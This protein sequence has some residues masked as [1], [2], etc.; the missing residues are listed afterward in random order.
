M[1]NTGHQHDIT[2][3]NKNLCT[4]TEH[5]RA[6]HRKLTRQRQGVV[7]AAVI[8]GVEICFSNALIF[9]RKHLNGEPG[10]FSARYAG[11]HGNDKKNNEKLL[12]KLSGVKREDR[13][14]R[15]VCELA[16]VTDKNEYFNV[17]GHVDGLILEEEYGEG[18]FGY[19]PLFLYE[20]FNKTLAE[21]SMEEKNKISHR[22]VAL[23]KA[24]KILEGLI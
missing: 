24:A 1:L 15:F 18:G 8:H 9:W 12:N 2:A 20:P 19:D 4:K 7:D 3:G 16:L 11:E 10:V 13:K 14:A 21:I 17:K 23:Q 6:T 5:H 22:G